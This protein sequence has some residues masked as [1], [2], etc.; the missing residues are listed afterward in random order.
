MNEWKLGCQIIN[1]SIIKLSSF[2]NNDDVVVKDQRFLEV[3]KLERRKAVGLCQRHRWGKARLG[4][5][6]QRE[7]K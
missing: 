1:Q 2:L 6:R 5:Y 7:V 4:V 3:N